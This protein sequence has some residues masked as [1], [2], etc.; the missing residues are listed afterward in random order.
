MA[1]KRKFDSWFWK[2]SDGSIIKEDGIAVIENLE[3]INALLIH[4]ANPRLMETI[5][6]FKDLNAR[7]GDK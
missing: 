4:T 1:R 6:A 2:Y 3:I 7:A 5:A